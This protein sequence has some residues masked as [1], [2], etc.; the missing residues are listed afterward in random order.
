M[1][2]IYFKEEEKARE[3]KQE[4][5]CETRL[6][7]DKEFS[8]WRLSLFTK[9]SFFKIYYPHVGFLEDNE[10]DIFNDYIHTLKRI[11]NLKNY[12]TSKTEKENI[13]KSLKYLT[14]AWKKG[15]YR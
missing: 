2:I 3:I 7:Y 13:E 6:L 1:E 8:C 4:Q 12:N 11:K 15:C 5:Y 10:L 14:N 9:T